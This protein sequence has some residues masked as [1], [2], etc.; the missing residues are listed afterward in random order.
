MADNFNSRLY[1][2]GYGSS[3]YTRPATPPPQPNVCAPACA[4]CG[5]LEC[6]CRP[7]FFA[8]QLLTEQDLN[9]LDAYI[10]AK[11]RMHNRQL[12]GWGVVNG[13]QV[14]CDPCGT[15]VIVG[16][17]Y[18]IDPCG[19]DIV[20]CNDVAVDICSLIKRCQPV[21]ITCQPSSR[22]PGATTCDEAEEEWVLALRYT[23]TQARAVTVLR[24]TP[25]CACGPSGNSCSCGGGCGCH[26]QMTWTA[27]TN[28]MTMPATQR[29]RNAPA[30]CEATAIC[31]GFSFDVFRGAERAP[32]I[33]LG[34]DNQLTGPLIE[35]FRCCFEPFVQAVL[36]FP[37][38]PPSL[39][40]AAI[41][42][43][44]CCTVRAALIAFYQNG[45]QANC[46]FVSDLMSV[47]CPDPS[48]PNVLDDLNTAFGNMLTPLLNTLVSCLCAALL[49]PAPCGTSDDR[50][51]L[52]IVTVR[53][54]DCKVLRVCNW[55]DLRKLVIT[56]PTLEYWLSWIPWLSSLQDLIGS[57]CCV[58]YTAPPKRSPIGTTAPAGTVAPSGA[59]TA[60]STGTNAAQLPDNQTF[61]T[62]L[63]NAFARGSAPI[64]P[65][66]V[67]SG[68]FGF[69]QD[70]K[71]PMTE[72]EKA[73]VAPFMLIDQ[74]LR[75]LLASLVP[76]NLQGQQPLQVSESVSLGGD[77]TSSLYNRVAALENAIR[78]MG[79][80]I[81]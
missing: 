75:P 17:G 46:Q 65:S 56:A 77:Q 21:D 30:E 18:A 52:A 9:R 20:V 35:A 63:M 45:S 14:R 1:A 41:W 80:K 2:R 36:P 7:R 53:K 71:Q 50:V 33:I 12:H 32:P 4:D 3:V 34:A 10:R 66:A 67:L 44:W 51:P 47:S 26:S 19:E 43:R 42:C 15:N 29:S 79:G 31:E 40:S 24:S 11:N 55:T 60:S 64:D 23:E 72:T 39:S 6:L 61:T 49:P 13:L 62:L 54:K 58:D 8:G 22:Y 37:P 28:P 25:H 16:T 57:F 81:P 69:K 70:A 78:E 38:S 68:V 73:N 5:L 59:P 48:D 27:P 76:A 74:L